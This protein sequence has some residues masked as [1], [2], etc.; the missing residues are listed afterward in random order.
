MK[1]KELL[2]ELNGLNPEAEVRIMTSHDEG[3]DVVDLEIKCVHDYWT[4]EKEHDLI[5]IE[6]DLDQRP[7]WSHALVRIE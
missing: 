5:S 4:L 2:A 6:V 7:D 3:D 1:L